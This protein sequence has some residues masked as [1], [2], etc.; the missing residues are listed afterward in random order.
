MTTPPNGSVLLA[1]PFLEDENFKR[2][3]VLLCQ[4]VPE[5]GT[6]G[7]VLNQPSSLLLADVV[8]GIY[9]DFPL[10]IGGP[11]QQNTLHYIHLLG[12]VIE[13]SISLGNGLFWAGNFE[14]IKALINLGQV[15]ANEVRFFLGYAGWSDGQLR[16]ELEQKS[17]IVGKT[18]PDTI[19]STNEPTL[20]QVILKQMGGTYKQFA[21]YPSDPKL[22]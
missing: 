6:F 4:H 18:T 11:V 20:W 8:E 9:G 22:N 3:V 16:D 10:Y 21:Y 15:K 14:Q 7:L 2:S 1:E 12:D 17:W 5:E 19:F 13:H